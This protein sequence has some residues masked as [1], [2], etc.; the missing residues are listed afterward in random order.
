MRPVRRRD[1][2][3]Q[4]RRL[5]RRC[6]R[7]DRQ[8]GGRPRRGIPDRLGQLVWPRDLPAIPRPGSVRTAGLHARTGRRHRDHGAVGAGL[9]GM[10]TIEIVE[11]V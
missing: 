10:E 1:H 6:P 11:A 9:D 3:A 2:G 8:P 7:T 5:A 4:R